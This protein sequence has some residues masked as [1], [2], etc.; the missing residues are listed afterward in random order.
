MLDL[1]KLNLE[2]K[3]V[4]RF[5]LQLL[6]RHPRWH[7]RQ[8]RGPNGGEKTILLICIYKGEGDE[9]FLLPPLDLVFSPLKL[10]R[11]VILPPIFRNPNIPSHSNTK[12]KHQQTLRLDCSVCVCVCGVCVCVCAHVCVCVCVCVCVTTYSVRITYTGNLR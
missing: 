6:K 1:S 12:R 5:F 8:D 10:F 7:L 2:A 4:D 3:R 9:T 11:R